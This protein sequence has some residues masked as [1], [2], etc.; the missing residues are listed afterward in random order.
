MSNDE[1]VSTREI[2]RLIAIVCKARYGLEG[3]TKNNC[4]VIIL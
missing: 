2:V 1:N 3:G 4:E